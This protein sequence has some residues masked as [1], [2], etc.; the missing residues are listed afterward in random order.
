MPG[1]TPFPTTP[2]VTSSETAAI[3]EVLPSSTITQTLYSTSDIYK[4]FVDIAFSPDYPSIN[5][6]NKELV[7]VALTGNYDNNDIKTI[8]NFL[9][10]FNSYSSTT[11]LP[12]EVQQSETLGDI[13]LIFLPESS[14]NNINLDSSWKISKNPEN[15]AINF[16]YKTNRFQYGVS[17]HTVYI[18]SDLKGNARTHWILRSLLYELG[19]PGETGMYPD[20]IFYSGSDTVTSLNKIDL[21]ALE[22]MYGTKISNGMSLN[23]IKDLFLIDS[24]GSAPI[25]SPVLSTP[26]PRATSPLSSTPTHTPVQEGTTSAPTE[27]VPSPAAIPESPIRPLTIVIAGLF[28]VSIGIGIYAWKNW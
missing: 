9:Q 22:L 5:K 21:K 15:G 25:A 20:S 16:I 23:K 27:A 14:L 26:T 28:V 3:P 12:K 17:T 4:H 10:V 7:H 24:S 13:V 11:K 19:F 18:N 2:K 1:T 8:N 6:W